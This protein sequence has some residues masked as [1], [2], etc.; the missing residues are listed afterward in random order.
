MG[1]RN[2]DEIR[3]D[4]VS[5]FI[6]RLAYC[7]T[8][9]LRRWFRDQ[10]MALFHHRL[11]LQLT[12]AERRDFMREQHLNYD[13][14]SR[15]ERD[16][17]KDKLV[18]LANVVE[19]NIISTTFYKIPFTEAT[20]L[21]SSRKVYLEKGNV[22]VPLKL[23]ETI[24]EQRFRS[25]L[26]N[27]LAF[28]AR[29]F[30]LISS[31][32]RIGPLLKNMNQQYVGRDYSKNSNVDKLTLEKVDAAAENHMPLCMKRLHQ[33]GLRKNNHL[34]H[35]GR[36][37]YGLFL[38][39]AGLSFEDAMMFWQKAFSKLHSGDV[40]EKQY[41]Y[42]F[43]HMY[44]KVGARRTYSAYS[45]QK[46]I[47]GTPPDSGAFH[48]CPFRHLPESQLAAQL[49]G[50]NLGGK[51][52]HDM[53]ALV[54]GHNY[55]LACQKHFD[56]THPDHHK[57]GPSKDGNGN[58]IFDAAANHPNSW[59]NASIAYHKAKNGTSA[60]SVTEPAGEKES[61][62]MDVDNSSDMASAKTLEVTTAVPT[63]E[64]IAT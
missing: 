47:L 4:E 31:D 27:A 1:R 5:H 2:K 48:G 30:D 36:L 54:K 28:A 60:T 40:F 32:T 3:K 57:L 19:T 7:R 13:E 42:N 15:E 17:L 56:L 9:E 11:T 34:K 23:V 20:S 10:E 37:Q 50:L 59:F 52:V 26:G 8:D 24:I 53:M 46:I 33:E 16:S 44:G 62:E 43:R 64:Q 45:C 63:V 6:L 12:D 25:Q 14:V 58:V 41:A 22:Y 51:E 21:V 29:S 39:G 49:Q 38:K 61:S 35:W 18:G 55:Q